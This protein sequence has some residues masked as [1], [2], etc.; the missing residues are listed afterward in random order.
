M[1]PTLLASLI[2]SG[3]FFT[4]T[5]SASDPDFLW[6]TVNGQCVPAYNSSSQYTPCTLVD[7]KAGSVLYKADGGNFQYLL[8][9][10]EK[11]TGIEDPALQSDKTKP[12]FYQAWLSRALLSAEL[13]ELKGAIGEKSISLTVNAIN[14]RSQNQLH[15][16]L[17]CLSSTASESIS[18]VDMNQIG[19]TW[20]DFP[21]PLGGHTYSAR[22]FT[23]EE[24]SSV[25]IFKLVHELV[26]QKGAEMQYTTIG[27]VNL[28]KDT[29][30]L[31]TSSGNESLK[32]GAETD[33][34]DHSCS[35]PITP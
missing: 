24:L 2:L 9:P 3:V 12:Y 19:T 33:L 34:Q 21:Q 16:H 5:A 32:V 27:L 13:A 23:L 8:L 28:D 6:N 26:Q 4:H 18:G 30:L 25:N 31:L 7:E 35:A 15:I 29:F 10:I 1:K 11:I 14:T 17:S 20:V 22:K